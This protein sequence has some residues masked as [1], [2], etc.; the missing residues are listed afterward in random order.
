MLKT[1]V[2]LGITHTQPH[3]LVTDIGDT[4]AAALSEALKIN[5]SLIKLFIQ[6]QNI[7]NKLMTNHRTVVF[8]NV[9]TENRISSTG[10]VELS[11]ALKQNETLTELNLSGKIVKTERTQEMKLMLD[12]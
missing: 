1:H 12:K 2:N 11:D 4:G 7:V 10:I 5:K 8:S 6:G 9:L 3:F